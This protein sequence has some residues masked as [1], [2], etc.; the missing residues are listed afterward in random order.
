MSGRIALV[1]LGLALDV[2][3]HQGPL[4]AGAYE[5]DDLLH[6]GIVCKLGRDHINSV[7]KYTIAKEQRLVRLAQPMQ[8]G[9]RDAATPQANHIESSKRRDLALGKTEWND[10]AGDAADASHHSAF[11]DMHELVDRSVASDEGAAADVHVTAEHGVVRKGDVVANVTIMRDVGTDHK[12]A[13]IADAR[14]PA[15]GF[16]AEFM[17]TPSRTSQRAPITSW[18]GSQR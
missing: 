18:V 7:G 5:R 17:V 8:R 14:N 11:A 2:G 16:S 1:V 9:P 10:V 4:T 3:T 13:T 6:Q 12:E 15:A